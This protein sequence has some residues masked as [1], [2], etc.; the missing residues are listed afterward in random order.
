MR[1][2][3]IALYEYNILRLVIWPSI[4]E[5]RKSFV[6]GKIGCSLIPTELLSDFRRLL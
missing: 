3:H 2:S 4:N 6:A 5:R 1:S